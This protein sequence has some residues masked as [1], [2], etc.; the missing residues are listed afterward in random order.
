[1]GN[2]GP[3]T[4]GLVFGLL[5][6]IVGVLFLLR[7]AGIL[8][9]DWSVVFPVLLIVLGAVVV[10]GA[11]R[12]RRRGRGVQEVVV[13]SEG[14]AGLELALR[15]GAGRY[16]LAGGAASLVEAHADD[17]TIASSVDRHGSQTRVRLSTAVDPWIWGW[18]TPITWRIAVSDAVPTVLDVQAGA[19]DFDL[20]LS[21][22]PVTSGKISVGAAELR[23][24]LP[25]P[26]GEVPIR[27]EGGAASLTFVVPAGVEA[28]ISS[29]G[30][31]STSGPSE[32]LGFGTARDRVLVS[33]TGG[34]ASVRVVQG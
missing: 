17:D 3:T 24:V 28:R 11:A 8:R 26:R 32:T 34:A 23:V 2:R 14:T 25:H 18:S 22:I 10:F 19:G 31:V 6:V 30:L 16:R 20:D 13:P 21:A 9:V 27:V 33:V 15:V 29:T 4:P 5:L 12:G 1:M 7:N